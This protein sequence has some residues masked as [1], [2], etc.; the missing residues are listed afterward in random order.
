ML[1]FPIDSPEGWQISMLSKKIEVVERNT[2]KMER[3]FLHTSERRQKTMPHMSMLINKLE[4]LPEKSSNLPVSLDDCQNLEDAKPNFSED[5]PLSKVDLGEPLSA[6]GE[7]LQ[8]NGFFHHTPSA[9]HHDQLYDLLTQSERLLVFNNET[10]IPRKYSLR[11]LQT[12]FIA[13]LA[14]LDLLTSQSNVIIVVYASRY[15]PIHVVLTENAEKFYNTTLGTP[16]LGVPLGDSKRL[17]AWPELMNSTEDFHIRGVAQ[18]IGAADVVMSSAGWAAVNMI[19]DQE[20][21]VRA[22]T[23]EARGIFLRRPAMLART[24]M[25]QMGKKIRDTPVFKHPCFNLE[26]QSLGKA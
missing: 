15:L 16:Y 4:Y 24:K 26:S 1:K 17:A 8:H 18:H 7:N 2:V 12:L 25:V 20:C 3:S 22:W 14:R 21:I 9:S 6:T 11:P 23:P 19:Q 10:I 5:H 13:G